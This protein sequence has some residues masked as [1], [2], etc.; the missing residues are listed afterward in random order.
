MREPRTL[1]GPQLAFVLIVAFASNA[2]FPGREASKDLAE[3]EEASLKSHLGCQIAYVES[4][5][6]PPGDEG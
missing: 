2:S 3:R 5:G 6:R 1:F 4:V